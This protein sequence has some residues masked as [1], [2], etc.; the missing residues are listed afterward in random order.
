MAK[1]EAPRVVYLGMD[2]EFS[3]R[4]LLALLESGVQVKA[5]IK[6]V[7]GVA[8]RRTNMAA[9]VPS[10][11]TRVQ[12]AWDRLLRGA[13][14]LPGDP[15]GVPE[16]PFA[17]AEPRGIPCY[18]V[19]DASGARALSI[20]RRFD[21][22]LYCVAFFN[23]LLRKPVLERPRLGAVNLHPSLLPAYRGPAPLFW[24]FKDAPTQ[25]GVTLHRI[26][27][28]EDD[29]DILGQAT[30][31]LPDGVRG[32]ELLRQMA[33]VAARLLVDGVW[34]LHRGTAQ[35]LPQDASKAFRRARP[36]GDD[37][38]V[39]FERPCREVFNFVRGVCQWVPL[40]A[41]VGNDRVDVL[42]AESFEPGGS[43]PGEFLAAGNTL[44]C[45][46]VDGMVVL[47]VRPHAFPWTALPAGDTQPRPG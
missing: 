21:V 47:R 43:L 27:P 9:R 39:D 17:V 11:W 2:S 45:R 14:P 20:L 34:A 36:V 40:H 26:A 44:L 10:L 46:C 31:P 38:R 23:Q 28:G 42:D 33:H 6:P 35:P 24:T 4:P 37:L 32:P 3:T 30:L 8:L 13:A 12:D 16:D 1:A 18:V 22:D 29:G 19:G 5:V 15:Q 25:T 7:G 41:Q